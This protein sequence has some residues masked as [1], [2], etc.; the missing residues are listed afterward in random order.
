MNNQ[1]KQT[2]IIIESFVLNTNDFKHPY[3]TDGQNL[4]VFNVKI[5]ITRG[6][7]KVIFDVQNNCKY[8]KRLIELAKRN[9]HIKIEKHNQ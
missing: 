1:Y 2:E 4:F 6:S 5:G 7:S 9:H 8:T 3:L